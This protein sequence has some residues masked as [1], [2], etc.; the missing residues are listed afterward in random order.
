MAKEFVSQSEKSKVY[1]MGTRVTFSKKL[2][3]QLCYVI[4]SVENRLMLKLLNF[5]CNIKFG[6]LI[7]SISSKE[8]IAFDRCDINFDGDIKINK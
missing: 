5:D 1:I 8:Y 2:L 4:A 3:N 7:S 6:K